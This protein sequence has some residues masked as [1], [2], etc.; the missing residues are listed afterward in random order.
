MATGNAIV[1]EL[2]EEAA[3]AGPFPEHLCTGRGIVICAGGPQMLANA[4]V[5]VRAL[6]DIHNCT[7]GIEIWHLG[8]QEMPSFLADHFIAMGCRIVDGQSHAGVASNQISDGWQLKACALKYSSFEEVILLDADQVPVRDPAE[9]FDW[10]QYDESGAVFWPDI[11]ELAASN[12]IWE[13]LGLPAQD[14]RSWESGQLCVNRR[15]HWKA[16]CVVF[17]MN[18]RAEV[19]YQLVY[20]DKDTF[21]FA[22]KLTQSDHEVIPHLPFQSERFVCQRDFKGKP[23]FQHR[24]NCKWSLTED[25]IDPDGFQ[26][27]KQ[28]EA[29]LK[30]LSA[31][32]DGRIYFAPAPT[33]AALRVET[34]LIAQKR[35]SYYQGGSEAVELELLPGNQF[36]K[37]RSFSLRNW[38]VQQTDEGFQLVLCDAQKPFA[39]LTPAPGKWSGKTLSIPVQVVHIEPLNDTQQ[40]DLQPPANGGI[41]ADLVLACTDRENVMGEDMTRLRGAIELLIRLEP[42]TCTS[43]QAVS[44]MYAET[45]PVMS[46]WLN[47]LA[48]ELKASAT[49]TRQEIAR[50]SFTMLDDGK[51]YIVR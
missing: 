30:Q 17:A 33:V 38:Y 8:R 26:Y 32:W 14:V 28:C 45:E 50:S 44:D 19:F 9:L 46:E 42:E 23:L 12:P 24:S 36:G 51:H 40:E 48:S 39:T 41:V 7:L 47:Q 21:L 27:G 5:L 15:R 29:F 10:P 6:R 35:F 43:V 4:Y 22:W 13:F 20:G 1:R 25:N 31:L 37:G 2:L 49:R 16:V 34:E 3:Q 18:R 11:V